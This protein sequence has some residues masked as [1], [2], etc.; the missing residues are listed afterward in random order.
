MEKLVPTRLMTKFFCRQLIWWWNLVCMIIK[1]RPCMSILFYP[2]RCVGLVLFHTNHCH[3]YLGREGNV[4]N[5][6]ICHFPNPY[7]QGCVAHCL[8]LL[9][10]DRGKTTWVKWIMKKEKRI[11]SIQQ[12]HVPLII[13]CCYE[14]NLMLLN[15]TKTRFVTNFLMVEKLFKLTLAIEQTILDHDWTTFVNL[16]CGSHHL[17]YLRQLCTYGGLDSN[18]IE[19]IWW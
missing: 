2:L 10:E 7:F 16:L 4:S 18:V 5:F 1:C 8:D 19:G 6:L 17:G 11:N 3:I 12:R 15:P 14:T 13:F 9:L